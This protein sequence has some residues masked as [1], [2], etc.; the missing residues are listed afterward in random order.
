[1]NDKPTYKQAFLFWLKLGFISFGG[2]AGQISIMHDYVVS[3]KKWLT[4]EKFAHALNYCMLLPG[5]EAQQ[6]ATY[7]GWL[8]HG[9]K[10]GLTAGL[11]F[12]LPSVFILLGLS[13]A[14]VTW[15]AKNIWLQGA[16]Y[17]LKPAV[18]ALI[19][20]AL[21]K[22]G[23]KALHTY[24]HYVIAAAALAALYLHV[25][26]PVVILAVLA[27]G[28]VVSG[29]KAE[30]LSITPVTLN[31]KPLAITLGIALTL[32]CAGFLMLTQLTGLAQFWQPFSLFFTKAALVTFGGAYSVLVYV[33]QYAV[34]TLKWLTKTEM[35]DGLAL[36]ETTPGPLIM[37][38]AYVGFM[39]A[40]HQYNYS[41]WAGALGLWAA[42]FFTFL[43]SFAFVLAGA[44]VIE[45]TGDIPF[46][47]KALSY[48]TA[49]VVGV[50][51]R[52]CIITAIAVI[53]PTGNSLTGLD[54]LA[55]AWIVV[56]FLAMYKFNVNV[57]KWVGAS[58]AF[59]IVVAYIA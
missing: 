30:K 1:M 46:I 5:P 13:M 41:L 22:I 55:L 8:L 43:P 51:A 27:I 7:I 4:E 10:G 2:P 52:L 26:Y 33:S 17:G 50:I 44:P 14:Y 3:K 35:I 20:V 49:A 32:W 16:L 18:T 19:I 45:R 9:V 37:V 56:S 48:V 57:I 15:H 59:G 58:I 38:L 34:D 31:I 39:G 54:Y 42:V 11:L 24:V 40:Y 36:G 6:L 28:V 23:N 53:F 25:P 29:N 47:K 12:I 21:I